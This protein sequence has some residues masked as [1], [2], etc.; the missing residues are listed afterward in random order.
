MLILYLKTQNSEKCFNN[1]GYSFV[2]PLFK[3]HSNATA[4]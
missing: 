1:K 3:R 4:L 2:K